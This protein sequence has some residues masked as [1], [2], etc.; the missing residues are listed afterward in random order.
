M[1]RD[2]DYLLT[3]DDLIFNV[4]G[5]QHD[6][7]F[8]TSGLKYANGNKWVDSYYDA[9]R[10]LSESFPTYVDGKIR[11]PIEKIQQHLKPLERTRHLLTEKEH[12]SPLLA[13][14]VDLVHILAEH[15]D[16]PATEIGIT[17]S[18]LWGVGN[19]NSDIDLVIY[20]SDVITRFL[21]T[22]HELFQFDDIEHIEQQY[23]QRPPGVDE[24][25]FQVMLQRKGNQGFYH[26]TRFSIRGALT[27][28]ELLWI[29][30]RKTLFRPQEPRQCELE[31]S[32]HDDSLLFPVSYDTTAGIPLVSYH[33]G[34]EM[35]FLPGDKV[36][37][38]AMY[39]TGEAG[40]RLL[41]GSTNGENEVIQWI[42]QA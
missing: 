22:S 37:V 5:D 27:D 17:D 4:L 2:K 41:V 21:S 18:L 25:T 19:E 20:G 35:S 9:A 16:V 32:G 24:N 1:Y 26:G 33:T 14:A 12:A 30:E 36:R 29:P 28:E 7:G 10:F 3:Q 13:L 39:E 34:Y 6:A 11:V 15:C 8:V 31:I 42:T 40:Q 38:S 23:V